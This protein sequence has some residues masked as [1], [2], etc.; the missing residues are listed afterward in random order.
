MSSTGPVESWVADPS[1]LGPIY[2][3]VG[4]EMLMYL[5]CVAFCVG[6]MIWKFST[7]SSHYRD[8]VVRLREGDELAKAMDLQ[9][10]GARR[11]EE[12]N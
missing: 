11:A 2:P 6:F 1:G 5:L 7:E 4:W 12:T 3:L 9:S 10:G 8:R